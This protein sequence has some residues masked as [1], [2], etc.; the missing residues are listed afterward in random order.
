MSDSTT[1]TSLYEATRR[2]GLSD[3][4]GDV[5][6]TVLEQAQELIG[7]DHCA[8]MLYDPE[9]ELLSVR[10]VRGYEERA[11][12]I[13]RLTLR[14]GD[15]VSGWTVE[16]RRAARVNDVSRDPRYVA[17]LREA[18]SNLAVP[19]IVANEVA[20]VINVESERLGAF[21]REHEELLTV[22]GS[23]AALAILAV[24]ARERLQRRI[25]QL[26]ALYRI[27][28]LAAAHDRLDDTLRAILAVTEELVPQGQVAIL[29]VDE[30]AGQLVLRAARGYAEDALGLRIPL[31]QGVTGRCA[32]SGREVVVDDIEAD[33]DYIPGVPNA[34][35][36]IAVPL[37]VEGRVI[38]VLNAEASVPGAYQPDQARALSV[39]AHQAAAVIRAAQLNEEARRLA[40]TDHLTGLHN[41]RYFVDKL[42]EH[43]ARA[44]RYGERLA[45]VL[46]D[47]DSLKLVNDDHG[48][49]TGDRALQAFSEVLRASLRA[50]DELAR[51]GG[52]EFAALLLEAGEERALAV[53]GRL[54]RGLRE[55]R[56]ESDDGTRL[57]LTISAGIALFPDHGTDA[58][59]LLRAA[60]Q[61][62]YA[63]KRRGRDAIVVASGADGAERNRGGATLAAARLASERE[64]R[65]S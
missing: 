35:S 46:A 62:L 21:T 55:T 38:G 15:G 34:R 33:P 36:E 8:L 6:D 39:V 37:K 60:D 20:G 40:V 44:G 51:I 3:S 1:L 2:I 24:R 12:D 49:L 65:A 18:R 17:G 31:G 54:R 59:S 14:K 11:A 26:N 58:K 10:R 41:R 53:V 19:L 47:A 64:G 56:L 63:A 5:L 13:L 16:H 48:H 43:L 7:F 29:L 57:R 28:Q 52:D 27:S 23:Q 9:T 30:A 61:A 32:A 4:L 22:L 25:G 50:S 45:L 42:E